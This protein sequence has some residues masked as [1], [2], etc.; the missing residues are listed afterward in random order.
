MVGTNF[1]TPPNGTVAVALADEAGNATFIKCTAANL[2]TGAGCAVGCI[3]EATDSGLLYYN[4][5]STSAAS[6]TAVNAGAAALTLATALTDT[7]SPAT[8]GNMLLLTASAL[9]SGKALNVANGN[10]AN[11]TTGAAL[12]YGNMGVATAGNGLAVIGTGA[13]TGTGLAILTNNT[14]TTGKGLAVSM[15]G[16]TTGKALYALGGTAMTTGGTLAY[17]DLGAATA[18]NGLAVITTGAY[19]G[20]G[21]ATITGD[22]VT[23]GTLGLITSAASAMTVAGRLLSAIIRREAISRISRFSV[24]PIPHLSQSPA[25][26][27]VSFAAPTRQW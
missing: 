14:A 7:S 20:T 13:Y 2:P 11:F 6:F 24:R 16:L 15:T 19:T 21:L 26:V 27:V 5:G 22:S 12:Y 3:A 10:A 4:T 18:G 23:T 8:T 25:I 9:T 1:Y 17:L